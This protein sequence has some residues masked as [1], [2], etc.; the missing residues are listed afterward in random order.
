[1]T[2]RLEIWAATPTPFTPSGELDL[3]PV[4][5]Q[6]THLQTDGVF[7]AFVGGTTGEFASLSVDERKALAERWRDIRPEGFGFGLQ[8][9]HTELARAQELA[10]HAEASGADMIAAVAPYYGETPSVDR[11]TSFLADVAAAAPNTPFC[12]Y[13]I[14]SMTGSTHRPSAIV[15]SA[16]GKIPTLN[17]VKFTDEDLMEFDFTRRAAPSV[18]VFFGRDELLPAALAFGADGVIGS[19]FNGLGSVAVRVHE[20][21]TAGRTAEAFALHEPFR[22]IA[23]VAGAHGGLGFIKQLMNE[24]SP[25]AGDPRLPWGPLGAEDRRAARELAARLRPAIEEARALLLGEV[26][27]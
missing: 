23:D 5:A 7:G 1:M 14:P 10:A 11:V 9:G 13:H 2:A 17:A 16:V 12:F 4:A 18:R 8:V 22:A 20:A 21:F 6:A 3:G 19:L 27:G 15:A 24:L 25:H 26:R